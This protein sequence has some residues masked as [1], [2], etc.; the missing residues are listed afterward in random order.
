MKRDVC[1]LL[2]GAV[3]LLLSG[4][5]GKALPDTAL[6]GAAWDDSWTAVGDVLGVDEDPGN[7]LTLRENNTALVGSDMFYASWSIGDAVPYTNEDGD[8]AELYDAQLSVLLAGSRT[9][10]AAR[11]DAQSWLD[12]ARSRYQVTDT[13]PQVY[14]GQEF[15]VLVFTYSAQTNPYARGACAVGVLGNHAIY[16]E[17]SCQDAFPGDASQILADFLTHCHYRT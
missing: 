15:T 14:N 5:G 17:L 11:E 9:R 2:A 7:G 12:M 8:D 13:E 1:L 3:C 16:A 6:D 10:D 4:C